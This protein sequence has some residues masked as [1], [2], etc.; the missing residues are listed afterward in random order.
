MSKGKKPANDEEN[1]IFTKEEQSALEKI[2]NQHFIY[3]NEKIYD[4]IDKK[5]EETY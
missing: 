1:Q 4:R 3:Q 5:V 2:S